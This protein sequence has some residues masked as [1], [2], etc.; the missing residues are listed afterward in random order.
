LVTRA[1]IIGL[2]LL[3]AAGEAGAVEVRASLDR[4]T[5]RAGDQVVLTIL[6]EGSVRSMPEPKLPDLEGFDVYSAGTSRNFSLVNGRMS[7]TLSRRY[8]L[9]PKRKGTFTIGAIAVE[10]GN[11]VFRTKPMTLAVSSAPPPPAPPPL[12]PGETG[13]TAG[14]ESIFARATVD[15]A[16]PY[17]YEQVTYRVRLYMR[18]NL[19]DNPGYSAPT[20]QGFW[21][22]DLPPRDPFIE[23]VDGK[24]YRVLEVAQALFPTTPGKLTIGES[25]L[26]CN[27]QDTGRRKDPF[28]FFGGSLLDGKRVVLRTDPVILDVRPLPPGAPEGF[29][30]AVGEYRLDVSADRTEVSQSDPVT[31]TVKLSGD[32]HLRTVG[33]IEL[34]ELPQFRSY[35]SQ[36]SQD[37]NRRGTRL[38]GSITKQFVLVPLSAGELTIPEV[39]LAVFSPKE[40]AYKTLTSAPITINA[41]PGAGAEALSAS[42]SDIELLGRDIRFIETE[43]SSFVPIGSTWGN[44]GTWLRMFP[45]P[46]LAYG[47]FLAWEWRRRRVGSDAALWRRRKAARNARK[48]LK[49]RGK[50]EPATRAGEAVRRYLADRYDLPLAGLIPEIVAVRLEADGIEPEPVTA[51]LDR[52]DAERYAPGQGEGGGDW[53][54]EAEGWIDTLEKQQ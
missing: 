31:L 51:F 4:D 18:A 6:A 15:K 9:I 26:E 34:P 49:G 3:A 41:T 11:E 21:R 37:I 8:V 28:S 33:D 54:D 25:V 36:S 38:G 42:R 14:S 35:P 53:I 45:L 39:D 32:G 1:L 29:A 48:F 16:N 47:G 10:I 20:T 7:S 12:S 23:T 46:V 50:T 13:S 30:G 24:K 22:E 40:S 17:L 27:V 43:M 2:L 5:V 19:L 52:T 44:A